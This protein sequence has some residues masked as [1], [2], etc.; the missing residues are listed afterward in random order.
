MGVWVSAGPLDHV[1]D[2][3]ASCVEEE[4]LTEPTLAVF[5]LFGDFDG[6][7]WRDE[8]GRTLRVSFDSIADELVG[9]VPLE[10]R[11]PV[12]VGPIAHDLEYLEVSHLPEHS[13][14]VG[15]CREHALGLKAVVVFVQVHH[16]NGLE[17]LVPQLLGLALHVLDLLLQLEG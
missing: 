1:S 4:D 12:I 10:A 2:L 7:D 16:L 11:H 17:S 9:E 15:L 8:D 13:K 6:L 5:L 14:V 3:V